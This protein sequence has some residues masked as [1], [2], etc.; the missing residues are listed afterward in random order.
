MTVGTLLW[1]IIKGVIKNKQG[2]KKKKSALLGKLTGLALSIFLLS[3]IFIQHIT[4]PHDSHA[5]RYR[6]RANFK[7]IILYLFIF[8]Y[9]ISS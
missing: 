7:L 6:A 4:N 1:S 9:N 8:K 3:S 2:K 5:P